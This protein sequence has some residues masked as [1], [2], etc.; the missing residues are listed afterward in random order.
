MLRP[1]RLSRN[2]DQG[3]VQLKVRVELSIIQIKKM[4]N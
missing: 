2:A 1:N 3:R 4:Q